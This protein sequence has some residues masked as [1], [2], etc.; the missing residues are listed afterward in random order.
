M[1]GFDSC[2]SWLMVKFS[3]K[4]PKNQKVNTTQNKVI[5]NNFR[6]SKPRTRLLF[7]SKTNNY[8]TTFNAWKYKAT[9]L[10][11]DTASGILP[12]Y[13]LTPNYL[14]LI[15]NFTQPVKFLP[16]CFYKLPTTSLHPS[17]PQ[18]YNLFNPSLK[19]QDLCVFN[20]NPYLFSTLTDYLLTSY[21]LH[22]TNIQSKEASIII[23]QIIDAGHFSKRTVYLS[24]TQSIFLKYKVKL[25][26]YFTYLQS[27]NPN[28]FNLYKF[29]ESKHP[30]QDWDFYLNKSNEYVPFNSTKLKISNLRSLESSLLTTLKFIWLRSIHSKYNRNREFVSFLRKKFNKKS[31][32]SLPSNYRNL[33]FI[34]KSGVNSTIRKNSNFLWQ[35]K[36]Q[37]WSSKLKV[38]MQFFSNFQRLSIAQKNSYYLRNNNLPSI[39]KPTSTFPTFNYNKLSINVLVSKPISYYTQLPSIKQTVLTPYL[40]ILYILNPWLLTSLTQSLSTNT[41]MLSFTKNLH[42]NKN[43]NY[44]NL[45]PHTCFNYIIS[46]KILSLFSTNKIREDI[47]PLY[48]NTLVRFMEHC[49][50]KKIFIQLY[51]FLNQNV[52]Y[53]FVVRYKS[54]ITRM[55]SYER[56]LGH[57]FFFEEALHI[58]HLSFVLR[59]ALLFSS[60]LK[61]IILR[62]SFWKTRTIFRFLRYL[63]LIYFVHIFP[64]LKIKGL[65]IRLKG[66]ISAAGNSRKRTILYRV[67]QTSHSTLDL[68]VSH[69]KQTINTF[70]GVMGFQV[71]LF[72]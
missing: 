37:Y 8:R 28:T 54:W 34:T 13:S 4:L 57:K 64:E 60:W 39:L 10:N 35:K 59:D 29:T 70:T 21:T 3:W 50:G 6:P 24:T 55:K 44:S 30:S 61:A 47:I 46:K 26:S 18:T 42:L 11:L 45:Q 32:S 53:D 51:P 27:E 33:W 7:N 41:I 36:K 25:T 69:S 15:K 14:P 62:I 49:S 17:L 72:Y 65:K 68:R 56:R 67:G 1:R 71:W 22:R 52:G 5:Y 23:A 63:F 38:N 19:V 9:T 20:S 66:K 58:M 48:Y 40:A 16:T 43:F 12:F 31:K 2:Y